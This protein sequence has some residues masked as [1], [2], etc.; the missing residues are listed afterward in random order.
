MKAAGISYIVKGEGP[1]T[2][3]MS[4]NS[5]EGWGVWCGRKNDWFNHS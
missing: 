1:F 5:P 2:S 4:K 3:D